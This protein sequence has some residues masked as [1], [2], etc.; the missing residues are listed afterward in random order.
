[1]FASYLLKL[2]KSKVNYIEIIRH[3]IKDVIIFVIKK[4]IIIFL[5]K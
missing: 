5:I 4:V 2:E 3:A 1:M